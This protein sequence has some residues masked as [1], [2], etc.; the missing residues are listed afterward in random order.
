[1]RC[2]IEKGP[3]GK[4]A[5]CHVVELDF[6]PP[7]AT[8]LLLEAGNFTWTMLFTGIPWIFS[9]WTRAEIQTVNVPGPETNKCFQSIQCWLT[10][11]QIPGLSLHS[12]AWRL[13]LT[14][15]CVKWGDCNPP[16]RAVVT[17]HFCLVCSLNG[18]RSM[19]LQLK[20]VVLCMSTKRPN[21]DW[22]CNFI[23]GTS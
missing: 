16:H 21:E 20:S 13:F 1:M 6:V 15:P 19:N 17:T 2:A 9:L 22:K 4:G 3:T 12:W 7:C 18:T 11:H 5:L 8:A 10:S 14:V 23:F